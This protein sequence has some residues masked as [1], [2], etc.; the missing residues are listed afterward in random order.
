MADGQITVT[1]RDLGKASK[2]T[3]AADEFVGAASDM[4]R[5]MHDDMYNAAAARNAKMI[6][7]VDSLDALT[8]ALAAGEIGFF[9]LKY[10]LTLDAA[11]DAIMETYK[12]SRRCLDD[13]DPTYVFVAKSY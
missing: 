10:D 4:L 3:I 13:A 6:K 11:F 1:R 8:A 12:V 9:R 5:A 2:Q 7:N